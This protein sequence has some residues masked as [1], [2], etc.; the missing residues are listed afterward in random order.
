MR[1]EARDALPNGSGTCGQRLAEMR[2]D[3]LLFGTL[4]GT[5]R[6]PSMSSEK[7]DQPRRDRVAGQ[8]AEGVA[9]HGVR[10]TS[11]KVPICGRPEGP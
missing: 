1:A 2:R 4:S 6:R 8:H 11:P 9:H 5:L 10:A 7:R 3:Q